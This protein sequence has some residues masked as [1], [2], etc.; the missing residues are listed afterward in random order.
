MV[1]LVARRDGFKTITREQ[2]DE[3]V[4]RAVQIIR[5]RIFCG[6]AVSCWTQDVIT[7]SPRWIQGFGHPYAICCHLALTTLGIWARDHN[8]RNG[9][10]YM[11]ETGDRYA[12][13]A[14]RMLSLSAKNPIARASYEYLSHS[15]L[16][17]TDNAATP[18]QAADFFAWEW[19]K[20][21]DETVVERKRPMRLSLAHLINGHLDRYRFHP[22]YGERFLRFLDEIRD[23]GLEELQDR[24]DVLRASVLPVDVKT[25][26][27]QAEPD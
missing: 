13:E 10:A 9:I 4:K 1:D 8:Y 12:D 15:F 18:L 22:M 3:L 17:K 11:F 26:I 27:E 6:V 2:G 21:F 23:L 14:H 5:S 16:S 24:N 20:F 25:S 19:G 7:H